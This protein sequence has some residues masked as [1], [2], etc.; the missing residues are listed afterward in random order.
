MMDAL[1]AVRE[2]LSSRLLRKASFPWIRIKEPRLSDFWYLPRLAVGKILRGK[3]N[4]LKPIR[5]YQQLEA[6]LFVTFGVQGNSA[7]VIASAHARGKKAVLF[8]GS[9]HDLDERYL[10]G[11]DY[12]TAY[13]DSAETCLWT[14]QNA[15]HI[16]CQTER[17]QAKLKQIFH[18][19]GTV[20]SNP[21]DVH[22]W[23]QRRTKPL[24]DVL[25]TQG[26]YVL[27]VGRADGVHKRPQLL[28][29]LAKRCPDVP[30]VMVMNRRDDVVEKQVRQSAPENVEIIEHVPFSQMPSLFHHA[31]CFINTSSLEGFANTFLQAAV[32]QV[33]IGSLEVEPGFLEQAQAGF[34]A[35]G[36]LDSLAQFVQEVAND[37]HPNLAGQS[38]R[39]YVV[40]NHSLAV[41][42][43]R[44][45]EVLRSFCN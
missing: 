28:I 32:S 18:R 10:R 27:W 19:D 5:F 40:S 33:P 14:I 7:T 9:D 8:L 35:N 11:G 6:D 2:S 30:F 21:I 1:Y 45:E 42:T 36:N 22:Q 26:D 31:K 13:H 23:D 38:A 41:Q 39:D 15:D 12:K 43:S 25:Q 29:D 34:Y 20:I 37:G 16:L 3:P 44:L 4:P 17:Q 24:P